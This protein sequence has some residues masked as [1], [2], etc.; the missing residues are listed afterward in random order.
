MEDFTFFCNSIYLFPG[1]FSACPGLFSPFAGLEGLTPGV[2]LY[3]FFSGGLD[4]IV[5]LL[6]AEESRC[7]D[8]SSL[9]ISFNLYFAP[10]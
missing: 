8:L 3:L 4:E 9:L 5:D 7:L 2:F 6:N 1:V 10:S